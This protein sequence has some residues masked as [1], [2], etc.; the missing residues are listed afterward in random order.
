FSNTKKSEEQIF[1]FGIKDINSKS[2]EM[3]TSGKNV[4]VE[5]ST[6][7]FEKI[8][9]TYEDGE[10]KSYGNEISIEASTIENAREI[11]NLLQIV[12]KD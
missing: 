6:K 3:I 7:Y 2:I 8:I 1:E 11:V 12:T 9:K 5:M 4:V 10:I